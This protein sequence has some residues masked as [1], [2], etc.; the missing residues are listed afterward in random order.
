MIPARGIPVC[1]L[2]VF[3]APAAQAAET[4]EDAAQAAA[5]Q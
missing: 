2:T 3:I 1:V 5:A 4:P